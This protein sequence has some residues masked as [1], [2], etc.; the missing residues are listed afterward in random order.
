MDIEH[1]I[2]HYEFERVKDN[3]NSMLRDIF[4]ELRRSSLSIDKKREL[5]I[6]INYTFKDHLDNLVEE[7]SEN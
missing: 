6:A 5:L 2:E 7:K 3:I 1:V 4:Q